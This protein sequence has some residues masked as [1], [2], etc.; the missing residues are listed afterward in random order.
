MAPSRNFTEPFV[1][2]I[3]LQVFLGY[4][5]TRFNHPETV[6]FFDQISLWSSSV[7][8]RLNEKHLWTS[9]FKSYHRFMIGF[10]R[11]GLWLG[12]F[13]KW[14]SHRPDLLL[15]YFFTN[16]LI[17][18]SQNCRRVAVLTTFSP[19]WAEDL[20]S[21]SRDTNCFSDLH[22]LCRIKSFSPNG[23]L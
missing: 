12:H 17:K 19:T 5:S 13:Y 1:L 15:D 4:V 9:V 7:S 10:S 21:S 23:K 6:I 16:G 18:K 20:C 8:V 22:P 2:R 11:S 14:P 3:Q